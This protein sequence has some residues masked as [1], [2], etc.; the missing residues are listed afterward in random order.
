MTKKSLFEAILRKS[1]L[2][3]VDI[4]N[5]GDTDTV[6]PGGRKSDNPNMQYGRIMENDEIVMT[7][8]RQWHIKNKNG[9]VR[10]GVFAYKTMDG[11]WITQRKKGTA[12]VSKK[13]KNEASALTHIESLKED[14]PTVNAGSGN[15][16]GIGVGPKGEPGVS[17]SVQKRHAKNVLRRAPPQALPMGTFWGQKTFIVPD[18]MVN[19]VRMQKRKGKWWTNYLGENDDISNAIREY[20]NANPCEPIILE[21]ENYG[22][23]VFARYGKQ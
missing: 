23:I 9:Y 16:A 7:P 11:T 4:D 8:W 15:I 5:D 10:N 1:K 13:H 3:K 21:G 22:H 12:I 14:A 18:R 2:D 17:P 19:E 6:A 20:A